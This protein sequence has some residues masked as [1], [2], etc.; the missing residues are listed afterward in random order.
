MTSQLNVDT[1]VDKAGTGGATLSKP[2]LT[3]IQ[4]TSTIKS[5]GGGDVSINLCQGLVK[6]WLYGS[7]NGTAGYD[8]FGASSLGDTGTGHQTINFS[9][10]FNNGAYV[11]TASQGT[12]NNHTVKIHDRATSSQQ[13]KMY[14]VS[15][16]NFEDSTQFS[17]FSGDLA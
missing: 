11:V 16:G 9:N 5:D 2:T 6:V 1:I 13:I 12:G 14:D 10:N 4:N 3:S 17:Q 15:S 7:A 8:S